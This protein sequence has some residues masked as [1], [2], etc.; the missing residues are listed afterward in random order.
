MR[1]DRGTHEVR[2]RACR[3]EFAP[4]AGV[5]LTRVTLTSDAPPRANVAPATRRGIGGRGIAAGVAIALGVLLF[6]Y[7]RSDLWLDEALSVN[8][9][10]LPLGDL[11]A[12]LRARRRAAAVLRAA[13]RLD[14]RVRDGDVACGR[15][16]AC[17]A[18]GRSSRCWFAARRSFG[19]TAAW[20]A[21]VVI[22]TNP[23]LIR[24]ATEARMY[25]LEM[26]L[27]A[28]GIIVV[29][30]ALERPTFGRLALVA[31]VTA[32][33][34]YTQYWA[35]YL[36]GVVAVALLV[37]AWRDATQR[38]AALLRRRARSASG[39]SR[40]SR[41]CPTFFSQRAHTGTPWG[42]PG[43][44]RLADRR[45]V[46]RV[47]RR[48]GA[49][50][51]APAARA[52]ADARTRLVRSRGRRPP[53]R[54][55]P[56]RRSRRRGGSRSIGGATLVVGLTLSYLAGQAFE[57]RYSAIVF[58]FFAL[59]V[60]RGLVDARR[61]A[62]AGRGRR[63]HRRAR[64]RRRRPQRRRAAHAGRAGRARCSAPRR[65]RGDLVVYCPD[66]LGPA[67]HRLLRGGLD[68]VTYPGA[69]VAGVRR[70]GRL[71]APARRGGPDRRSPTRWSTRAG[72]RNDLVRHGPG[73]PEPPRRVRSDLG[74]RLAEHATAHRASRSERGLLR[75]AG[76]ATVRV[77][78]T[79]RTAGG[80]QT[81]WSGPGARDAARA[82]VVP[83][84]LSRVLV[85]AALGLTREV[86]R[87]LPT[88]TD[89]IQ[90]GQGLHAWD[91]AFY[92]DIA[93]GGYD[94]VGTDGLRF[95][96]L[97]PL[98]AR[99]ARARTGHRHGSRD[100]RR[101]ER[102]RV[103]A[104]L[105]ALPAGVVRTPRRCVRAPRGVARVPAPARV[106]ARHG[107][108]R[109]D[110]H[111]ARGHRA[112]RGAALELVGGRR[113]RLPRRRVPADR[114]AA[115]GPGARRSRAAPPRAHAARHHRP[116]LRGRG[117]GPRLL[118]VPVVGFRPDR[119]LPRPAED[120]GR[121][122]ATRFDAVP[123]HE[124]RRRRARLLDRRSRHRRPA[125]PH[126]RGV[127]RPAVRARPPLAGVVHAVRARRLWSSRSRRATST[128]SS[129]TACRRC[130]SCSRSPTSSTPTA[131]SARCS[132]SPR[133]A[134]SRRRCSRS[135]VRWF[136]EVLATP[137]RRR[138]ASRSAS[139]WRTSRWRRANRAPSTRWACTAPTR[140]SAR[141]ATSSSTTRPPIGSR[142]ATVSS[143]RCGTS[144]I[145]VNRHRPRPI[146]R[147]S[148][149]SCSRRS[150]GWWS[151]RRSHG[152]RVTISTRTCGSTGTR[153]CCSAPASCVLIGLLGRRVGGDAVG[154]VAAGIAAVSPNIWVNDGLVM[155]E[156]VTNLTVVGALLLAF[157]AY[158]RP[159][160]RRFAALGAMCGLA[161]LARAELLLFVPLLAVPIAWQGAGALA[162]ARCR[163]RRER[164][165]RGAVGRLQPHPLRRAR[166]PLDERRPRALRFEL[167]S[168]LL[169]RR[170]RADV[171]R[172]DRAL[173]RRAA[174]TG[175]P[176]RCR[177]GV[178][179]PGVRLRPR[180][181]GR[182]AGR[183]ARA[184][185]SHVEPVPAARH[186]RL[187]HG[188][189]PR[190][191]GDPPR[192]R[193][194]L[195][196]AGRGR[197][198]GSVVVDAPAPGARSGCCSYPSSPSRSRARSPTVRPGSAPPAEPSL[199]VLAAIAGVMLVRGLRSRS[200]SV[201][202]PEPARV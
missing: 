98:L 62:R 36:V 142:R 48:R 161:A 84:V 40:S 159:S 168:R 174:A 78:G 15:S 188:R 180:P 182:R 38:R 82:V 41:G 173:R 23:F 139:G 122:G 87:D 176:E 106:R 123:P 25:M 44:A 45:D 175:R 193:V 157:A 73:L 12:A 72:R 29:P 4:E 110:V 172:H 191:V 1:V 88:I 86:V 121:P 150:R 20:L 115:R 80:M 7:S 61:P 200:S 124:R 146:T 68:E 155:S 103:R 133:P 169:R 118:R 183:G 126:G 100:G 17:S 128:R 152:S 117:A 11:R 109:G 43:A 57:P 114:F 74:T 113:R 76:L 194:L 89:P 30:R 35:F 156:T 59:L 50:G 178:S 112:V 97:F 54:A 132:C 77:A 154:L 184:R 9:A 195:P 186:G 51:L 18:S 21:V 5:T 138:R 134:S 95:F 199:A 91:A 69:R 99:A 187:Q 64:A 127:R 144:R 26:L 116:R 55:R 16:R 190:A 65:S 198:R 140:A 101:R 33:L 60:G 19:T 24:Y 85:I 149:C 181:L 14:R 129:A 46:P 151:V 49:G 164:A 83:F 63:R 120:P 137:A 177:Q 135:P 27:V 143:N 179:Q 37:V 125:S 3:S 158:D 47:R 111:A 67:V 148:P 162:G 71:P 53:S 70:L 94:A 39:C 31:L 96:P 167:R 107:L 197:G 136:R 66:Q 2:R 202:V 22:A 79:V 105:R 104:R 163:R 185:R 75:E 166:V 145:R 189:R 201:S 102:V 28:C 93:R 6:A 170:Y 52:A 108:R 171:V 141:S 153:W 90:V 130:R 160:T 92:V 42:D 8:I 58:P 10:R 81:S 192:P 32:L 131:A 196:D 165:R 147:R 34:V 119:Q 56:P 13:A